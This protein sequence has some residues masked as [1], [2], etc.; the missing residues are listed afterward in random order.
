M[1]CLPRSRAGSYR[2]IGPLCLVAAPSPSG[3]AKLNRLDDWDTCLTLGVWETTEPETIGIRASV[4]QLHE[5]RGKF[6]CDY[7]ELVAVHND[8]YATLD[9]AVNQ[10]LSRA[11]EA[12]FS[13][14]SVDEASEKILDPRVYASATVPPQG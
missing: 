5:N 3:P 11:L 10:L 9:R 7:S 12:S 8:P 14:L 13:D 4:A 2:P 6:V 1:G